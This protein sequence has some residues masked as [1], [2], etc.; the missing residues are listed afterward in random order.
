MK[1]PTP[2][3]EQTEKPQLSGTNG[4]T[5]RGMLNA[6]LWCAAAEGLLVAAMIYGASMALQGGAH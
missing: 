2:Y 5:I 3:W 1:R 6:I 4:R